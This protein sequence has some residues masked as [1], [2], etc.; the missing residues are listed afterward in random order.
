MPWVKGTYLIIHI[1][2]VFILRD[3]V[4]TMKPELEF[5]NNLWGLGT[6]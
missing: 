6:K 1:S 5:L 4:T 3:K 2:A